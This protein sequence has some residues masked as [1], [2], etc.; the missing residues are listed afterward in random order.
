MNF[1]MTGEL[2][3]GFA[4]TLYF[5]YHGRKKLFM[6]LKISMIVSNRTAPYPNNIIEQS[7]IFTESITLC[8]CRSLRLNE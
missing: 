5:L 6:N 1:G 7:K 8:P 2:E 4:T 3:L